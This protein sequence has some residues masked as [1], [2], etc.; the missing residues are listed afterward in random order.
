MAKG[1]WKPFNEPIWK[2]EWSAIKE[3]TMHQKGSCSHTKEKNIINST[4]PA[5]CK[6]SPSMIERGSELACYILSMAE[7]ILAS[8]HIKPDFYNAG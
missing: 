1:C 5:G 6:N 7:K 8:R 2:M 3:V 4:L